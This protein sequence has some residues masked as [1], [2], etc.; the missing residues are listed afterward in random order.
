VEATRSRP[1]D[2]DGVTPCRRHGVCERNERRTETVARALKPRPSPRRFDPPLAVLVRSLVPR[3][4]RDAARHRNAEQR[5]GHELLAWI[6]DGDSRVTA[7]LSGAVD[8]ENEPCRVA[9]F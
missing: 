5:D 6:R 3:G 4:P 7:D 8:A 1:I 9:S 2:E